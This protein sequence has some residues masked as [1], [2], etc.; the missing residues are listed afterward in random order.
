LERQGRIEEAWDCARQAADAFLGD[1]DALYQALRMAAEL[2]RRGGDARPVERMTGRAEALGFRGPQ[3]TVSFASQLN[4]MGRPAQA[5]R[6]LETGLARAPEDPALW[7]FLGIVQTGQ[8]RWGK[9]EAASRHALSLDPSR[10]RAHHTLACILAAR[11]DLEGAER[12]LEEAL[13]LKPDY[14][15]AAEDLR[16]LRERRKRG[17]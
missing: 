16:V 7:E 6:V 5:E 15:K 12:R 4:A 9:A 11:G 14:R 10:P 3:W 13:R 8:K 1:P 17:P 2:E